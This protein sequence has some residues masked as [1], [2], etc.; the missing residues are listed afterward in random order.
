MVRRS[1]DLSSQSS[2]RPVSW[3][4]P[5]NSATPAPV[6]RAWRGRGRSLRAAT[7]LLEFDADRGEV[8]FLGD[9]GGEPLEL[10]EEGAQ[11]VGG[12]LGALGLD[13]GLDPADAELLAA[14]I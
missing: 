10:V 14:R 6:R 2:R 5:T 11:H 13:H 8:V 1:R 3:R 7:S 12:G 4:R 9:A